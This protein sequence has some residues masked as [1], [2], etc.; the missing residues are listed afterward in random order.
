MAMGRKMKRII[1]K[2]QKVAQ[3]TLGAPIRSVATV[4]SKTK[5]AVRGVRADLK[6]RHTIT[7]QNP[8]YPGTRDETK[9]QAI[10]KRLKSWKNYY[11]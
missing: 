1:K 10:D 8:Y 5:R 6:N 3:D 2:T 7:K 11:K 9:I 4:A